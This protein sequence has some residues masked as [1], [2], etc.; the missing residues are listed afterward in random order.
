MIKLSDI[1]HHHL[2][3]WP[4]VQ[5]YMKTLG[6]HELFKDNLP[7]V[8]EEASHAN[9]LCVLIANIII[10]IKPLSKVSEWLN[11]YIDGQ[12]EYGYESNYYTDDRLGNA[13]DALF[14]ADRNTLMMQ[15]SSNAIKAHNLSTDVVHNDS[16]TITLHGNYENASDKGSIQPKRGYNKDGCPDAK[17]LI[18]NLNMLGEGHVPIL[19]NFHDGNT[20]DS[21]THVVNWDSIKAHLKRANFLYISDSKGATIENM[22]HIDKHNGKFIS[23]LPGSRKEVQ[24]FLA[25]LSSAKKTIKWTTILTKADSRNK[26]KQIIYQAHSEQKTK[27]GYTIHWIHSSS[28]AEKDAQSRENRLLKAEEELEQLA[29]KLNKYYLKEKTQISTAIK[30]ILVHTNELISVN[31]E[32]EP[33]IQRT[34]IGRGRIGKDSKFKEEKIITYSITWSRKE[35]SIKEQ[36]RTDGVFPLVTNTDLSA[37]EVLGN[38][39]N[40]P[41]LEKKFSTLKSVLQAVPVYLKLPHRIEAMLFLYFIA[42]MVIALMERQIS[43]S[44]EEE[45]IETLPILPQNAKT[46]KPTWNNMRY[47]FRDVYFMSQQIAEQKLN[48]L[49]KSLTKLHQFVL[50]LLKVPLYLYQINDVFWWKFNS[51]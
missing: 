25:E 7:L 40:Q 30:K 34:K 19:A 5:H 36:A 21:D 18:F 12:G 24:E 3:V 4:I 47:F 20:A 33:S 1:K 44:M 10:S 49:T 6:L 22:A 9:C 11:N 38:Y 42:L 13:L 35:Q 45:E 51:A 41:Y 17:Q 15:A 29:L 31:I 48:T 28:K 50:E 14:E 32:E 43:L 46:D 27:E 2:D 23:I 39:K 26:Q 8:H 37:K 16:T